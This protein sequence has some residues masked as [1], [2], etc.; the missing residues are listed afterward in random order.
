VNIQKKNQGYGE[1]DEK[2]GKSGKE[3]EERKHGGKKGK[4]KKSVPRSSLGIFW[5]FFFLGLWPGW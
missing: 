1:R 2:K 5:S 3:E 4:K